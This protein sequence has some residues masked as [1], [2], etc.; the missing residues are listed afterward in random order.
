MPEILY[1]ESTSHV[2]PEILNQ[3]SMFL[4]ISGP[5]IEPFRGDD[6]LFSSFPKFFIGNPEVFCFF[7]GLKDCGPL[8]KPFRGDGRRVIE[9]FRSDPPPSFPKSSIG[10]PCFCFFLWFLKP[11]TPA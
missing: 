1:W 6:L 8:I 7:F 2:M 5:L 11:W 9:S 3:A 4:S 10:N